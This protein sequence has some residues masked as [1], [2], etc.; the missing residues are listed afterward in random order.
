MHVATV[1]VVVSFSLTCCKIRRQLALTRGFN[2]VA[3]RS[4]QRRR[5]WRAAAKL[6]VYPL[7][8]FVAWLPAALHR[9]LETISGPGG[10]GSTADTVAIFG[11]AI[12]TGG[13]GLINF[14]LLCVTNTQLRELI[15]G[16]RC[17]RGTLA[18]ALLPMLWLSPYQSRSLKS[19]A[20]S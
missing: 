3:G 16:A 20:N 2:R 19:A 13:V 5:A 17:C 18:A 9:I 15:P 8:F 11:Y 10:A 6:G 12:L 14:I 4:A 7:A 1:V